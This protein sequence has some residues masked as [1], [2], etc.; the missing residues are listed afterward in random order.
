MMWDRI[1]EWVD[2]PIFVKHIR[3]R[4]RPQPLL[5]SMVVLVLLNLCL[6]YAGYELNLYTT[7]TVAGWIVAFQVVLL[8]VMGAAQVN[9]SVNGAR[10]SGILDFH[11]V[12]PLTPTE[13]TLGFF[14]G[15]P[16]R[17]YAL[18]AATIPFTVLCMAFGVP[19][20]RGFL[21]LMIII[22]TTSWTIHGVM[23]LNGLISRA[24]NPTGGVVGVVVF[25]FFFFAWIVMGAQYSVNIVENDHRLSFFGVSLPWLP[26]VLLNQL[27]VLFFLLLAGTRKMESQRLHPLSKPQALV[28]MLTFAT[29][30][31]G[32]IWQQ[33]GYEIYEIVALYLLT[34][35][36]ILLTMMI[37][38]S[39]AE[40]TK[41][42]FRARKQGK[43]RLPWW[44]DLSVNWF[45]LVLLA[46]IVLAAGTLAGTVAAGAPVRLPN[47]RALGPY[48]LALAA[49]VLTVAYFGLAWQYFQLRFRGRSVMYLGLFLFIFWGLPLI[50]GSI[51]SM[52]FGPMRSSEAGY[53]IFA[54]SPV[55][56][57][58]MIAAMGGE[59]MAY[60]VQAAAMTP[61]LLFTFVFNYLLIGAR[62]RVIKTVLIQGGK[63]TE[64][65]E[66]EMELVAPAA[67]PA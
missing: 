57:I 38:P 48:P 47:G 7:G 36:A 9:A 67:E 62:R 65:D 13:L 6:A 5:S 25:L 3:S 40:Y 24:K 1:R 44:D 20:F 34:I 58:G 50:A 63:K 37:T 56:G 16:I 28:A 49:A 53:P 59:A 52:A 43:A 8:G 2:N 64:P 21:Q 31:L 39:Q 10:A 60:P 27:P 30:V 17:E 51:H 66:V 33:E 11:R 41:G 14:F 45:C 35:P 22:V 18:F 29:L 61:I 12:S 55:A 19:S 4:L 46:G 32:G 54:L 23:L 26:V 42:L 15:A